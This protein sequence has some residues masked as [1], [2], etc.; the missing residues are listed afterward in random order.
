MVV[1]KCSGIVGEYDLDRLSKMFAEQVEG[2][3]LVLPAGYTLE[4]VYD[5][6]P[7]VKVEPA[8]E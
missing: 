8:D 4:G 1:I 6:T 5:T 7:E 3:V 2:G